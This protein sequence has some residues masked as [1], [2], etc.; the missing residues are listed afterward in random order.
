MP[1]GIPF[2]AHFSAQA[3]WFFAVAP[4]SPALIDLMWHATSMSSPCTVASCEAGCARSGAS[5]NTSAALAARLR[6]LHTMVASDIRRITLDD[7]CTYY[8][9]IGADSG[10]AGTTCACC[11]TTRSNRSGCL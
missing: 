3:A 6:R 10:L 1:T 7:Y 8:G 5:I 11:A 2:L 4:A 9:G